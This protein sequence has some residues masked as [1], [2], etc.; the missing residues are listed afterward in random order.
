MGGKVKVGD[1]IMRLNEHEYLYN[2][3]FEYCEVVK[4]FEP[5]EEKKVKV[6]PKVSQE[7]FKKLPYLDVEVVKV[8]AKK[9]EKHYC[10]MCGAEIEMEKQL[11]NWVNGE[12]LDK[13]KFPCYCSWKAED[14][15]FYGEINT[16]YNE[17]KQELEYE[18]S[19][20]TKQV[21]RDMMGSRYSIRYSSFSLKKLFENRD[22]HI[23]KAKLTLF[24]EEG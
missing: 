1:K 18:L 2:G 7:K 12:N 20:I 9:E 16:N 13:I 17:H 19:D 24:E 4:I 3:K 23:L 10:K 11:G 14:M 21:N 6:K 15:I 8:E 22:I 5:K